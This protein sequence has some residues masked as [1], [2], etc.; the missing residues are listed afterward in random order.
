MSTARILTLA[1]MAQVKLV[2]NA[3]QASAKGLTYQTGLK[4][5]ET[6]RD[7]T[8]RALAGLLMK[9]DAVQ[10]LLDQLG[11]KPAP[12]KPRGIAVARANAAAQTPQA[13]ETIDD[14]TVVIDMDELASIPGVTI[15][16]VGAD[17]SAPQAEIT[18]GPTGGMDL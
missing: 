1:T 3:V 18:D 2:D 5:S 8:P 9:V 11:P 7:A 10:D 4:P 15:T 14:E 16:R 17:P 6:L 12:Q 13:P